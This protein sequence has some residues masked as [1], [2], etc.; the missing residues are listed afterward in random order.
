M[1]VL[2]GNAKVSNVNSIILYLFLVKKTNKQIASYNI[3]NILFLKYIVS[4]W[5]SKITWMQNKTKQYFEKSTDSIELQI[6]E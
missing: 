5:D 1:G 4:L 2:G 3:N 6:S